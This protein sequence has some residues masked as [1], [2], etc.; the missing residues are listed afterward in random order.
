M[1]RVLCCCQEGMTPL[2]AACAAGHV[3]CVRALLLDER[4]D[5]LQIC[6]R[7]RSALHWA[8]CEGHG[9]VVEILQRD[10]RAKTID[11][12]EPEGDIPLHVAMSRRHLDV[13]LALPGFSEHHEA[14]EVARALLEELLLGDEGGDGAL[15]VAA[16]LHAAGTKRR[17]RLA[18]MGLTHP[19]RSEWPLFSIMAMAMQFNEPF[20]LSPSLSCGDDWSDARYEELR[21][22]DKAVGGRAAVVLT[23]R[24]A[25]SER[26]VPPRDESIM[27]R[28]ADMLDTIVVPR[29]LI[30]TWSHWRTKRR[31]ARVAHDVEAEAK[32]SSIGGTK[33]PTHVK[34]VPQTERKLLCLFEAVP[35]AAIAEVL[36]QV[37]QVGKPHER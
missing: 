10:P 8:A 24:K 26:T 16:A 6:N 23:I 1:T 3:E 15:P 37:G 21:H 5:V 9:V 27:F 18:R 30:A 11:V 29:V 32:S 14:S 7:G 2:L 34:P 28:F 20:G 31:R 25:M 35:R 4:I 12:W 19:S 33:A 17:Q 13:I 22:L 36:S